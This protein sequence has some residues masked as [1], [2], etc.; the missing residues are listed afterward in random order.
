VFESLALP[1]LIAVL[2]VAIGLL[3]VAYR[4]GYNR[5]YRRAK[6]DAIPPRGHPSDPRAYRER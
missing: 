2:V 4:L 6:R 1:A 3:Y 5:G